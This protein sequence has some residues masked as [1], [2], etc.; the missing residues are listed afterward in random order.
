MTRTNKIILSLAILA[1]AGVATWYFITAKQTTDKNQQATS[2]SDAADGG[3]KF[4]S[5]KGE[6]FDE[7]YIGDMISHHEGAVNMAEMVNGAAQHQELKDMAQAIMQAQSQ[8]ITKMRTWQTDW[9]YEQTMG[10]HGMHTGSANDMA[11]DMMNMSD[12]LVDLTGSAFDKKFL[13]LM[14]EHHQQAVDMSKYADANASHAEVKDL[15]IMIISAQEREINQMKQWQ[16]DWGYAA[17][18]SDS[19]SSMSGMR[20]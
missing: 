6:A 3:S 13:E 19:S 18:A 12:Q 11:G 4:A 16:K 2:S 1:V 5:L 7:A 8:E 20:H 9:G 10:G 14:I 17:T 15:A